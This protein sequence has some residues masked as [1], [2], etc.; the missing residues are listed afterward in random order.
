MKG[1]I[2]NHVAIERDFPLRLLELTLPT[3]EEN[4]ALDEA[5]LDEAEASGE[6]RETLRLWEPAG[7]LVVV[8]RSSQLAA[9]VQE[10]RCRELAIPILRRSSGGA[11]IVTGPGCLMYALVLSLEIRP[12]LR[13]IDAAHHFVLGAIAGALQRQGVA[14]EHRGTSD[15]TLG[16]RKFSGNSV[17]V[18]REHLLY[19]GTLLY[20]FPLERIADCLR[21]PPRQPDYRDGRVHE[22]F[23]T[24]LPLSRD[25]LRHALVEAWPLEGTY[26]HWPHK[27]VA[28]L[29]ASKYSQPEWKLF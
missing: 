26:A 27:R 11:A 20:D 3:P 8:G 29:V 9:E 15:L 28:A 16:N 19:H 18:R 24:N 6:P 1:P 12:A 13:A 5:L 22:Q 2:R 4:L 10:E 7:P 14:A 23:V 25:T 21:M 17:R